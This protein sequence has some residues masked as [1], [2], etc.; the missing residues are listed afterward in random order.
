MK[1]KKKSLHLVHAKI[2]V[3]S[4][5]SS[6]SVN[7]NHWEKQENNLK[8]NNLISSTIEETHGFL[9]CLSVWSRNSLILPKIY[10]VREESCSYNKLDQ[11]FINRHISLFWGTKS[12]ECTPRAQKYQQCNKIV[13]QGGLVCVLICALIASSMVWSVKQQTP[14]AADKCLL[15]NQHK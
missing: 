12:T 14:V 1:L 3:A 13:V 9:L 10:S 2:K 6:A 4:Y 5:D 11:H 8:E 15:P 7:Q